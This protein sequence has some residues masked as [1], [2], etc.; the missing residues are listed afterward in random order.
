MRA[1]L[2]KDIVEDIGAFGFKCGDIVVLHSSYR[3]IGNVDGGPAAVIEA[4]MDVLLP[5]GALLFPNLN[6]PHE[7]TVKNPPRF[8]LKSGHIKDLGIIPE[9]FKFE[10][11][12]YFSIH[13][14][15]AMMGIGRK[16]RDILK[17]HEKAGVPCGANTPWDK[18]ARNGGK[19]L[20]IGVNQSSNTTKHCA[21]EQI[22][23]SFQLSAETI[24]GIV[25]IDGKETVVS[26]RLHRWGC[27]G[28]FNKL[29]PELG[30]LGYLTWGT[31]GNAETMCIDARG[32]VE[33]GIRK[34]NQDPRW[35]NK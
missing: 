7:F 33:L 28:D 26:S 15:H 17:N 6:I 20:L 4:F 24:N 18:N 25:L 35:F 8:D 1:H 29:N 13:T 11:A 14:T 10:Y 9:T 19:L 32:F 31:I 2:K 21:E 30:E 34:L 3:K 27:S 12:E 5:D 16:A 23:D 22:E